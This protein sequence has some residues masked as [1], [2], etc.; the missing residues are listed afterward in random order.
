MAQNSPYTTFEA[1]YGALDERIALTRVKKASLLMVLAHPEI[2]L[3]NDP[4]ELQV[5]QRVR[6]R[7]ISFG[8]RVADGT[9]TAVGSG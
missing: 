9:G 6:K 8:P 2:P 1:T 4:V 7:K 3:H 5:R